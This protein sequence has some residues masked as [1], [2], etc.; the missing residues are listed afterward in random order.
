[1]RS[2]W[3]F[4]VAAALSLS[5]AVAKAPPAS[6]KPTAAVIKL[7]QSSNTFGF[8]L[9]Q[10][11]RQKPGNLV[12]SP[13]SLSAALSM[14][15]GGARGE[16]AAQ[17]KKALHLQGTPDE[18]LT[19]AGQLSTSLQAPAR[20]VVLRFA[21]Q[22]F[23]EK[24]YKLVPAYVEKTRKTFG[25]PLERLDFRTAPEPARAHINQWVEGITERRIRDLI[26]PGQI[27]PLTRLVLVNAIYFLGS[28]D[29][30]FEPWDT[31]PEPFYLTP[32]R[33]KPVPTMNRN[34][35][36]WV[37]RKGGVTAV[38]L[39]YQGG[40]LSMLILVPDKIDGLAAVEATLDLKRLDALRAAMRAEY[41]WLSLPKFELSPASLEL[42]EHLE[43]LGMRSAFDPK[44]ADLTGIAS[45]S[46]RDARLVLQDVFHKGFVRVDEKG[47]EAAATT[48]FGSVMGSDPPPPP[49][50]LQ[51]DHPFLFLIRD[52][53]SGVIL[54]LGRVSDPGGRT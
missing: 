14:A 5:S 20:P 34:A 30:P 7:A 40:G 38:E 53:A 26:P 45:P 51:V 39:P 44:E 22:L 41:I 2:G 36:L 49:R 27:T 31:R 11:L 35:T 54:F 12:I 42:R 17:M 24:T 1:M 28:W 50:R 19:A 21:N 3:I 23:A 32:S 43:A 9:Y 18:V 52:N 33:K 13:A 37:G 8:D 46:G 25:A 4:A 16:T 6:P 29:T 15:W 47:T 10:R 48:A